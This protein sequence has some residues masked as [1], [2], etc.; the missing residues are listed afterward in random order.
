MTNSETRSFKMHP[1]LLMDVI[2]RQAGTLGKAILE[3]V[4][5]SIEAGATTVKIDTDGTRLTIVD[6][7]RGFPSRTEIEKFFEVFGQPHSEEEGKTY[8]SFRMGRGQLFSFG[9]NEWR[10]GNFGMAVDIAERGLDYVL[11]ELPEST[12]GCSITVYLYQ[13]LNESARTY[14]STELRKLVRFAPREIY[15]NGEKINEPITDTKWHEED[16]SGFYRITPGGT[17]GIDVFNQGVHVTTLSSWS[18][19]A[20]GMVVTKGRI[21]INFARN[22]I[23]RSCETWKGVEATI[24]RLAGKDPSENKKLTDSQRGLVWK[25]IIANGGDLEPYRN[26]RIFI[27]SNGASL[28]IEQILRASY[29]KKG[30][31]TIL[32]VSEEG[33]YAADRVMQARLGIVLSNSMLDYVGASSPRQFLERIFLRSGIT[34]QKTPLSGIFHNVPLDE[35]AASVVGTDFAIIPESE[36]TKAEKI[37][38]QIANRLGWMLCG[39]IR[40]KIGASGISFRRIDVGASDTADGWTDGSTYIAIHR[41]ILSEAVRTGEFVNL[42]LLLIHEFCHRT[43]SVGDHQHD[44]DFY[45]EYHDLSLI[46]QDVAKLGKAEHERIVLVNNKRKIAREARKAQV[47]QAKK[48]LGI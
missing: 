19:G 28:S 16:E 31:K 35:L 5:N 9:S 11:T 15:F 41:D 34:N 10:S 42:A 46:A 20:S 25:K 14:L 26:H 45:R 23:M 8:A 38:Q 21:T 18:Y 33:A 44:F 36:Y 7:G 13:P 1:K 32:S 48:N 40:E 12:S 22:D 39:K 30:G 3:G 24:K 4:M 37:G 29:A 27:D 43:G 17:S 6:D 47:E 2:T